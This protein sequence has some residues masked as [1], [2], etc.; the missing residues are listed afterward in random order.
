MENDAIKLRQ[1]LLGNLEE[2]EADKLDLILISSKSL[3]EELC[4][5][6]DA[7]MEDYL[8]EMLSSEEIE[9]FH[10]NFL[11][12][13]ARKDQLRELAALKNYAQNIVQKEVSAKSADNFF[14]KLKNTFTLNFRP[15][16]AVFGLLIVGILAIAIWQ[17][18]LS[19]STDEI[20]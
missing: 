18:G 7:L 6:E 14:R 15:L 9:L 20:A 13:E 19:G 2:K 4:L 10:K 8:D 11:T 5:A 17:L 16:A 1:Y 3:E 12:S